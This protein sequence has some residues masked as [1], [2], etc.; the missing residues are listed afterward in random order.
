MP[1]FS[2]AGSSAS[3]LNANEHTAPTSA[4]QSSTTPKGFRF[5]TSLI[6]THLIQLTTASNAKSPRKF[7]IM[8]PKIQCI[9]SSDFQPSLRTT[10]ERHQIPNKNKNSIHGIATDLSTIS[11][12]PGSAS[13][14]PAIWELVV[15]N[16]TTAVNA[17]SNPIAKSSFRNARC[18]SF[19]ETYLRKTESATVSSG[20]QNCKKYLCP[21]K[22]TVSPNCSFS[23]VET[24]SV[25][26][27]R[28]R[29]L[30]EKKSRSFNGE[31]FDLPRIAVHH[32]SFSGNQVSHGGTAGIHDCG[33][34]AVCGVEFHW[35][36]CTPLN[37]S[38]QPGICLEFAEG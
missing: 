22:L 15:T 13:N 8:I 32:F 27:C 37:R 23:R 2:G 11:L 30:I 5:P 29:N 38:E 12:F 4:N 14:A 35:M 9:S 6:L 19:R 34:A 16:K 28:S 3:K 18:L 26:M 25:L 21:R 36:T 33:A 20:T 1:I 17:R 7:G 31:Y 10:V 24:R